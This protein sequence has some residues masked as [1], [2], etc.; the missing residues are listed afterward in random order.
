MF[1]F[2][3][4]QHGQ[5]GGKCGECG[6]AYHLPKPRAN[7]NG[8]T[9]GRG[10]IA[11]RYRQG[12]VVDLDVDLNAAHK[13]HFEFRLCELNKLGSS[14]PEDSSCFDQHL[15]QL[16]AGGTNFE[17]GN[18]G[19]G[20][21]YPRI[22]LPQGV[23]C[24]QCVLQWYYQAGKSTVF[25]F[26]INLKGKRFT[27]FSGSISAANNWGDCGNGTSASGCGPQETFVNCADIAIE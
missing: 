3:Q 13:G 19:P 7:E 24:S 27:Q 2:K 11:R 5:N 15:L 22:R 12:Q 9:Y 21:Y 18:G 4:I 10:V 25:T 17:I 23:T 26:S 16:E 6:D 20:H 14:T 1:T 8:G